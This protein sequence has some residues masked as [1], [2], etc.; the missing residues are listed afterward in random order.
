MAQLPAEAVAAAAALTRREEKES[1]LRVAVRVLAGERGAGRIE[2]TR[3]IVPTHTHARLDDD[4]LSDV[5]FHSVL[6]GY[7]DRR[8][9]RTSGRSS[10]G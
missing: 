10:D 7:G 8:E 5:L 6:L 2:K 1:A 4:A 3:M 9:W